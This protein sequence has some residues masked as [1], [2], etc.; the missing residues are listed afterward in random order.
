LKVSINGRLVVL[1]KLDLNIVFEK[2]RANGIANVNTVPWTFCVFQVR[3]H[4]LEYGLSRL[5]VL[6]CSDLRLTVL[7]S[8]GDRK[9]IVKAHRVSESEFFV[10]LSSSEWNSHDFPHLL[11][12]TVNLIPQIRINEFHFPSNKENFGDCS[13]QAYVMNQSHSTAM[14]KSYGHSQ[15]ADSRRRDVLRCL[16]AITQIKPFHW[17]AL[18]LTIA[19]RYI[20]ECLKKRQRVSSMSYW[21]TIEKYCPKSHLDSFCKEMFA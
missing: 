17:A 4:S 18:I 2:N 21:S 8:F 15:F 14:T 10:S 3:F 7:V 6:T 16:S 12:L 20:W 19:S 9:T 1:V 5:H 13:N 11:T